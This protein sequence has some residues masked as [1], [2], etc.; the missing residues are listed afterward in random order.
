MFRF[1]IREL[2]LLTLAVGLAFGWIIDRHIL[3][4]QRETWQWRAQMIAQRLT[5]LGWTVGWTDERIIVR[6][7]GSKEPIPAG[8]AN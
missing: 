2:L 7:P 1:T 6:E 4:S 8:F 5:R 3:D